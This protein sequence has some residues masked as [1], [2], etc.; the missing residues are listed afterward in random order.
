M[1]RRWALLPVAFVAG[2]ASEWA[3]LGWSDPARWVPD[4]LAGLVLV[5]S[6]LVMWPSGRGAAALLIA[7]GFAWFAG[8]LGQPFWYWHRAPLVHLLLAFPGWRPASCSAS[9]RRRAAGSEWRR[10]PRRPSP[11]SCT[12]RPA[13]V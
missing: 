4:L 11:W 6:G 10:G 13:R 2:V 7:A 1:N 8:N 12:Q 9:A 3:V 5:G